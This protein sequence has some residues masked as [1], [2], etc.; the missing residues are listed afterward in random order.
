MIDR[1][2][3]MKKHISELE[4]VFERL[5]HICFSDTTLGRPLL[6][7]GQGDYL[8]IIS[9]RL[10]RD[11]WN[12]KDTKDFDDYIATSDDFDGNRKSYG[13]LY[14]QDFQSDAIFN[15]HKTILSIGSSFF[16]REGY[17]TISIPFAVKYLSDNRNKEEFNRLFIVR[18]SDKEESNTNTNG[19]ENVRNQIA[20]DVVKKFS[21][22]FYTIEINIGHQSENYHIAI[23]EIKPQQ[24][25]N[26]SNMLDITTPTPTELQRLSKKY[27]GE[28]KILKKV[29][30]NLTAKNL[31]FTYKLKNQIY[32]QD[33]IVF[34]SE[35]SYSSTIDIENKDYSEGD[36]LFITASLFADYNNDVYKGLVVNMSNEITGYFE[37]KAKIL[38]VATLPDWLI[39]LGSQQDSAS[40][41]NIILII[42]ILI[43]LLIVY[44]IIYK[45]I[46]YP[47]T[48]EQFE[49]IKR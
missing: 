19:V 21:N 36:S 5:N 38:W 46:P 23:R 34:S 29:N 6:V 17:P 31:L 12:I 9:Y 28:I 49:L 39:I 4:E 26:F 7:P 14:K 11:M 41:I 18:I 37:K 32:K 30:A 3:S 20:N 16:G 35:N 48:K 44:L 45:H 27:H 13:Y 42:L 33:T 1:S 8:S 47:I 40:V 25:I 43:I 10:K 2:G 24:E 15:F 22:A